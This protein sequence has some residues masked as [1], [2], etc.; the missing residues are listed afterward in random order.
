MRTDVV[1]T[2]LL[3]FSGI[4]I[5]VVAARYSKEETQVFQV[6]GKILCQDCSKGW[7]EW[8]NGADPLKGAKVSVTCLDERSRIVH[9]ASDLTDGAGD[10]EVNCNKY[11]N[12]KKINPKNC[13]LRLVSS[14]DPVCNVAT[15]FAGGKTGLKLQRPAVVYRDTVKYALGAFYYTTPMCDEP[16]TSILDDDQDDSKDGEQGHY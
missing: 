4:C 15:N 7:N 13:F 3:I 11:A 8:V 16:D 10:F 9:Y 14:P 1:L 2:I 6:T 12:G 5:G